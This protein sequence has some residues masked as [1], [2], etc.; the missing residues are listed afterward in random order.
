MMMKNMYF[1][2]SKKLITPTTLRKSFVTHLKKIGDEKL[3][4]EAASAMLH[5]KRIQEKYYTKLTSTE[6]AMAISNYMKNRLIKT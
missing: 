2:R 6:K 3:L 5:S 1:Q 4:D